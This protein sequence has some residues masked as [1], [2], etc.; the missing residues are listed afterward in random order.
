[1]DRQA[2]GEFTSFGVMWQTTIH[3]F[4]LSAIG[5]NGRID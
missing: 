5:I 4:I 3:V 1:M 2:C